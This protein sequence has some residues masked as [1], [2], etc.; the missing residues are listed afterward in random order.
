MLSISLGPVAL[1]AAPL[2]LLVAIVLATGLA[3]RL[4]PREPPEERQRADA[5]VMWAAVGGLVAA[6]LAH[7]ALNAPAYTAHP[8][9]ALDVRDGGWVAGAGLAAGA[10]LLAWQAQRRPTLRRALGGGA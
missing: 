4:A 2:L 7:L 1:P 8:W 6:R 3:R 10:A 9:A 5:A